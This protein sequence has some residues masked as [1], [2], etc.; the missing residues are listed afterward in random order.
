M[1]TTAAALETGSR[2]VLSV[3]AGKQ[4]LTQWVGE[5]YQIVRLDIELMFA[6]L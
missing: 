6:R 3:G 1:T 4:E 2:T 5:G